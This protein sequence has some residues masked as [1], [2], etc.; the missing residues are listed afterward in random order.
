MNILGT[1]PFPAPKTRSRVDDRRMRIAF[2]AQKP[3]LNLV[4]RT[5]LIIRRR[6]NQGPS[7]SLTHRSVKS[8]RSRDSRDELRR[9]RRSHL[10]KTGPGEFNRSPNIAHNSI[11]SKSDRKSPKSSSEPPCE[12]ADLSKLPDT[13]QFDDHLSETPQSNPIFV[14]SSIKPAESRYNKPVIPARNA[15]STFSIRSSMNKHSPAVAR[16]AISH[17]A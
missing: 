17:S 12:S 2:D 15:P 4:D 5:F 1:P 6:R 16:A 11:E 14:K 8:N 7:P 10:T 13:P 3:S 9:N